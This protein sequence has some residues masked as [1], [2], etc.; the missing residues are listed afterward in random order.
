[1]KNLIMGAAKGYGWDTLEPFVTSWRR[2]CS[3]AELV[4]FVDDMSPFTCDK[5]LGAGV[6]LIDV[7]DE[8]RGVMIVNSRF[9]IYADFLEIHGDDFAQVFITDTADVIF[10]GDIFAPFAGLTSWLGCATEADDIRGTK[11]GD[12]TNYYWLTNCFGAA[13][14]QRLADQ[15]IICAGT[16]IGST[17][18]LKI[19][20]RT[21]WDIVRHTPKNNFDQGTMNFLVWNGLLPIENIFELD[22]DGG[23]IFTVGLFAA[24]YPI[25]IRGDFIL[26]GD[27]QIPAVVHQYN[28]ND[29]WIR[30]VDRIY[31]DQN[32]QADLRFNDVRS[33][34]EQAA[35]LL[36][37]DAVEAAAKLFVGK[38]LV[39]EDLSGCVG[40]LL[41]LWKN[42]MRKPFTQA[43][44]D[45]ELA[46]Q[47]T[48]KTINLFPSDVLEK[49]C[50]CLKWAR[51]GHHL[52]DDEF[53]NS[54]TRSLLYAAQQTSAA[55]E[56]GRHRFCTELL[57]ILGVESEVT[58]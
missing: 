27:G 58:A 52:V 57:K 44:G 36:T 38:L 10:Q 42:A 39:A 24:Q 31:R 25:K 21:I 22:V 3:D 18:A 15:K 33:T 17:D 16:I 32:F 1:M 30:L 12:R 8:L 26:R 46:V 14:A 55:G 13:E 51:D 48:L 6:T 20:C 5:L 29:K 4:L 49:I 28:R 43:S 34:F 37:V 9:K 54:I 23:E 11:T 19:L 50:H 47:A 7:P 53:A 40:V 45:I 41:Q 35:C 56:P 2:N